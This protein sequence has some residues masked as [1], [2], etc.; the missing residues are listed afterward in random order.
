MRRPRSSSLIRASAPDDLALEARDLGS[1]QRARR[2]GGVAIRLEAG[3]R[4]GRLSRQ[5][6]PA[7]FE[8]RSG[9][10]LEIGN[11]G[12]GGVEAPAFL[13][14]P[15]DRQ[16]QRPLGAVDS[17]GR[18]AHLLVEDEKGVAALQF[19]SR[20]SHAAPEK[21]Q[22]RFEHLQLPVMSNAHE[23]DIAE[24]ERRSR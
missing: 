13:L 15:G 14:I 9:A 6:F 10:D 2:H 11:P 17:G 22:N 12:I 1:E 21:R 7:A 4:L 16:C 19:F 8:R 24:L 18:I 3:D 20:G 23:S 5:I